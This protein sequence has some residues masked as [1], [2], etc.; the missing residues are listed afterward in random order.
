MS[1]VPLAIAL[2]PPFFANV[3]NVFGLWAMA[4]MRSVK[5]SLIKTGSTLTK[6]R[7]QPLV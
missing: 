4:D 3:L 1:C 7:R 5:T 6:K 2:Q